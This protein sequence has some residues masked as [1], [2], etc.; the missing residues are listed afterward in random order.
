MD[1]NP[2]VLFLPLFLGSFFRSGLFPFW[3]SHVDSLLACA[4]GFS[5]LETV[6]LKLLENPNSRPETAMGSTHILAT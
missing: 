4:F 3:L 6:L 5:F 1:E 2:L